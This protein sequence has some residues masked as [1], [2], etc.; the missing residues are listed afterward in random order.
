MANLSLIYVFKSIIYII[1]P[2]HRHHP[3]PFIICL[4]KFI[5]HI[6][7]NNATVVVVYFYCC[8]FFLFCAASNLQ[9]YTELYSTVS[10]Y[11][12]FNM[13]FGIVTMGGKFDNHICRLCGTQVYKYPLV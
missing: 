9:N 10:M 13:G 5:H 3:I 2:P 12:S 7:F 8:C 11:D 1:L 4:R 6:D